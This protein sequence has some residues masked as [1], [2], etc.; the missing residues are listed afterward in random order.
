MRLI[1]ADT[2]PLVYLVLIDH[3]HVLPQL[4]ETILV[5]EAVHLELRNAAAPAAIQIWAKSLPSWVEVRQVA[6]ASDDAELISR[7]ATP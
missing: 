4:F 6:T 3:I 7:G 2:S 1:V 5:P